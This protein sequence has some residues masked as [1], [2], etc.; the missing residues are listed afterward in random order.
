MLERIAKTFVDISDLALPTYQ[1]AEGP[2]S[3]RRSKG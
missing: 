1:F 3:T 2:L